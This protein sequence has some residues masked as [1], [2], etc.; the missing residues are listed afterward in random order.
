MKAVDANDVAEMRAQ[1]KR[2][3]SCYQ[4][5]GQVVNWVWLQQGK[6]ELLERASTN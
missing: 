4:P 2:L 1:I 3:V 5:D 6:V